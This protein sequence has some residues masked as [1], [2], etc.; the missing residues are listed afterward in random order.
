MTSASPQPVPWSRRRGLTAGVVT[1]LVIAV[2]VAIG[3]GQG[4]FGG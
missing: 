2:L 3:S 4:W 1:V